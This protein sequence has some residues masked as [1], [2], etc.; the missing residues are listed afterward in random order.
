MITAY[1]GKQSRRFKCKQW[2]RLR[3]PELIKM[4]VRRLR[5]DRVVQCMLPKHGLDGLCCGGIKSGAWHFD[6]WWFRT[7]EGTKT[8]KWARD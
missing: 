1:L 3:Y 5:H 2:I 7:P 4:G 6:L 8:I